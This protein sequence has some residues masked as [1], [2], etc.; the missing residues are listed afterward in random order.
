MKK[1]SLIYSGHQLDY[2]YGIISGFEFYPDVNIDIIDSE[3]FENNILTEKKNIRIMRFLG[4]KSISFKGELLRWSKYYYKL[5]KYLIKSDS[6]ILHIEWIN[7]KIDIFE[8]FYFIIMKFLTHKKV[9]F[10]VHDLDTNVL[11]NG[12][13][14]N[15][16]KLKFSNILFLKNCDGI[17]THNSFVKAILECNGIYRSKIEIIPHGINNFHDFNNF[18]KK[19]A[20]S[21]LKIGE[22]KKVLLFYGNIRA[23]K[24]L[25]L[26]LQICINL[27]KKYSNF[28]LIVAG[29]NDILDSNYN[30][31]I[32]YLISVLKKES[33]VSY[34]PEFVNNVD[35]EIYF[36]ASDIL[37]LPY[38]FI[39]Q[40]GLPFLSFAAGI[41]VLSSDVGGIS[42]NID[43]LKNGIVVDLNNLEKVIEKFLRGE[44]LFSSREEIIESAFNKYNWKNI[45]LK[46]IEFYEKINRC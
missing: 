6:E 26:L 1:V 46:Q 40:S 8:H 38:K 10:K 2:L 41:P 31:K 20:K 25:D 36:N 42:E 43:E 9:V 35:T 29:K 32:D 16:S 21:L 37:V 12:G 22:D 15:H 13:K 7:R 19:E 30:N 39:Y 3:R 45:I 34:F 28:H 14:K 24:S 11:L 27:K 33:C 44:L 18:S 17:I 23:Y 4:P 5:T